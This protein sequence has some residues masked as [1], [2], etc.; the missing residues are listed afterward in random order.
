MFIVG[1]VVVVAPWTLRN[2]TA[3][4]SFVPI[5]TN[6][7]LNLLL[8]NNENAK[9]N[10]GADVDI[11]RY[12]AMANGMNEAETD[13]FFFGKAVEYIKAN[14]WHSVGLYVQKFFLYFGFGTEVSTSIESRPMYKVLMLLSYGP[15]LILLLIRLSLLGR[16]APNPQEVL[17]LSIL[18]TSGLFFSFF[19]VRLR[20]RLPFDTL[21][22]GVVA[23][24]LSRIVQRFRDSGMGRSLNRP[25]HV[26]VTR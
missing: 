17:F 6:S 4:D 25:R 22:V 23:I 10:S 3:F 2:Y 19:F 12:R 8:G 5:S 21:S 20:F 24:F 1:T 13:A 11:D 14:K 26:E 7:G 15:I 18:L 9:P 16:F